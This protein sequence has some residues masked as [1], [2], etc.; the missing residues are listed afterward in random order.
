MGLEPCTL[1][2]EFLFP[3]FLKCK[4]SWESQIHLYKTSV[5]LSVKWENTTKTWSCEVNNNTKTALGR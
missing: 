3:H 5:S 1:R 2:L 4:L